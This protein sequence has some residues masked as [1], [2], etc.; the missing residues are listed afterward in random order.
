MDALSRMSLIQGGYY[1]ASGLWPI[2]SLPSFYAVTGPKREGWLVKTVGALVTAVGGTL[3]FAG[4][5]RDKSPV[6]PALGAGSAAAFTAIDVWYGAKGTISW[7]YLLDA[8]A[9]V[10]LIAGWAKASA[11]RRRQLAFPRCAQERLPYVKGPRPHLHPSTEKKL[12]H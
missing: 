12:V 6:V 2:V 10:G 7:I 1:A 8:V 3:L 9:Q 11:E 4:A 5:R